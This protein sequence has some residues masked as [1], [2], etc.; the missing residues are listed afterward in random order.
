MQKCSHLDLPLTVLPGTAARREPLLAIAAL[1]LWLLTAGL[2][3]ALLR[4]GNAARHQEPAPARTENTPV[5]VAAVPLTADGKPPPVPRTKVAAPPGEHPL[6]E[7][8]H[9]ALG[10]VGLAFWFLFTFIHYRMLAWIAFGILVLTI[11]AGLSWLAGNA[12]AAGRSGNATRGA[13]PPRLNLLHGLAATVTFAL[14][15]VAALAA[16]RG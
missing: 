6:L 4:A 8:S 7:F 3:I 11:C 5:R 15:V 12:L 14:V 9:P 2:G 13:V 1:V 16:S 10:L